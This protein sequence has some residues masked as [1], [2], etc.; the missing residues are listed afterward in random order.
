[1]TWGSGVASDPCLCSEWTWYSICL[2]IPYYMYMR[3][4]RHDLSQHYALLFWCLMAIWLLD[5]T[6]LWFQPW[7]TTIAVEGANPISGHVIAKNMCGCSTYMALMY[8]I[9][10]CFERLSYKS[11]IL[12]FLKL[13]IKGSDKFQ[14]DMS[15]LNYFLKT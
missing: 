8:F 10:I 2:T 5:Y 11:Y 13:I 7:Q 1:M 4:Q 14:L 12:N 3:N 15:V 6:L 9:L